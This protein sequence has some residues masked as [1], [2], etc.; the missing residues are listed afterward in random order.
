MLL[1][2]AMKIKVKYFAGFRKIKGKKEEIVDITENT[3]IHHLLEQLQI[4][5]DEGKFV[6]IN[7]IRKPVEYVLKEEDEV[8][9]F[10]LIGGG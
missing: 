8:G 5:G 10:P 2:N 1:P 9:V 3:T 7:G 4:P 6:L